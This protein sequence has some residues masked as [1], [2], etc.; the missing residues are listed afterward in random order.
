MMQ[1]RFNDW[2]PLPRYGLAAAIHEWRRRTGKKRGLPEFTDAAL[3]ELAR[4]ALTWI[5]FGFLLEAQT[6]GAVADKV[7]YVQFDRVEQLDP[8]SKS[9]QNSANGYFL[10]PHV[11]TSN[12]SGMMVKEFKSMQKALKGKLDKSYQLKRSFSPQTSKINGGTRSMSD[13]KD[14]LLVAAFTAIGAASNHKAAALDY[15]NFTNVGLIPD[16]PFYL[17]HEERYPLL[18]YIRML[19]LIQENLDDAY[20][21]KYD[22]EK[23]KYIGRPRIYRGNYREAPNNVN[24]GIVQL[25]AAF[26]GLIERNEGSS[27]DEVKALVRDLANRPIMI[28]GY[29]YNGQQ[30]FGN[31]LT[32]LT[33]NGLLYRALEDVWKVELVGI[34]AGK[35][36]SSPNWEHFKRNLDRWLRRFDT[37]AFRGFLSVRAN[38]PGTFYPLIRKHFLMPEQKITEEIVD[39]AMA[40]GKSL[41]SAAYWAADE[42]F[43]ND[44]GKTQRDLYEY[45]SRVLSSLESNIRSAKGGSQLLS[46]VS[47]LIGRM[48]N[49]DLSSDSAAFMRAVTTG[50]I[51]YKVA[52]D[53]LIAFMRLNQTKQKQEGQTDASTAPTDD[54]VENLTV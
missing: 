3:A 33:A 46:Q 49:S 38:Y 19:S 27:P 28:V 35:K 13:P 30:Q 10:A 25:L 34:D 37:P 50:E 45:K 24:F 5:Q 26:S 7:R 47:T 22:P 32:D 8:G 41:N 20:V 40:M 52:Q 53:L 48:T 54:E 16:I 39:S 9:G 2:H 31:H 21:G 36:Y 29:D 18:D 1:D 12:N 51:D 6:E 4:E 44:G 14:E 11:L 42:K 23:K 15:D 43:K 17:P